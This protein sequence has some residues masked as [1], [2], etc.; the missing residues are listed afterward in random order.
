MFF[1]NEFYCLVIIHSLSFEMIM[2]QIYQGILHIAQET[3]LII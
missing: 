3:A 2:N 1:Y